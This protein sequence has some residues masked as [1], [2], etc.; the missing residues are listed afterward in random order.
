MTYADLQ[1]Q[2]R[3][4]A[5]LALTAVQY[6]EMSS[7]ERGDIKKAQAYFITSP[8]RTRSNKA[9]KAAGLSAIV[10]DLDNTTADVEGISH[11]LADANV[12]RF[13]L[14]TSLSHTNMQ[15]RYRV[16]IPLAEHAKSARW[17]V[18]ARYLNDVLFVDSDDCSKTMAQAWLL[19]VVTANGEYDFSIVDNGEP[20]DINDDNHPIVSEALKLDE[21]VNMSLEAKPVA[22][23][24]FKQEDDQLSPINV[25]NE[26]MS[27]REVMLQYGYIFK[28]KNRAVHPKSE[29]GS[30]GIYMF[31][32]GDRA[33]SHHGCDPYCGK[34]FDAFD[35]YV[36]FEHQ[37]NVR[38]A[39][40]T[41]GSELKTA[42]GLSVNEHNQKLFQMKKAYSALPAFDL[43]TFLGKA[44][45][46]QSES[47]EPPKYDVA[48]PPE[49]CFVF[50]GIGKDIYENIM[51]TAIYPQPTFALAATLM[52]MSML[53][54]GRLTG[55]QTHVRSN[56]MFICVGESGSG[57]QHN[58]NK[59]ESITRIVS[60]ELN[61]KVQNKFASGPAFWN[62]L[63]HKSQEVLLL[64]D[65]CGFLFSAIKNNKGE[66][67]AQLY[68]CFLQGYSASSTVMKPTVYAD[69]ERNSDVDIEHPHIC[70]MGFTT[71]STLSDAL[72][73][74]DSSTGLLPRLLFF[75]AVYDVPD[76][77][78]FNPAGLGS[79]ALEGLKWAYNFTNWKGD[80]AYKRKY[81]L[82]VPAT[83]EAE[84]LLD[85]FGQKNR[86]AMRSAQSMERNL[87]NRAEENARRLALVYWMDTVQP[88]DGKGNFSEEG[89]IQVGHV[90][91]AIDLVKWS[92]AYTL[93]FMTD[94]AGSTSTS[95]EIDRLISIISQAKTYSKTRKGELFDRHRGSLSKGLMPRAILVK[96]S[97]KSAKYLDELLATAGA[98]EAIGIVT[99]QVTGSTCYFAIKD[100]MQMMGEQ[101]EQKGTEGEQ[102]NPVTPTPVAG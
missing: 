97:K 25:Y 57:K 47:V 59:V 3:E 42:E 77:Q 31:P 5:K 30:A 71:E 102:A 46:T 4:P 48:P 6:Q 17:L 76:K 26:A 20:L 65:E 1:S 96:Q 79:H 28:S 29:S 12:K 70:L 62:F 92:M 99:D 55:T 16:V 83:T 73:H 89:M 88:T 23:R 33:Y 54:G 51:N 74:E 11:L 41:L 37:G 14:Y 45:T 63:G 32:E 9:V 35:V 95:K 27:I 53:G 86:I 10:L 69:K 60:P 87:L 49:R 61:K 84:A 8:A 15:P 40:K 90:E 39:I 68:D 50:S 94:K 101:K 85:D 91:Q 58:I 100:Q 78:Q 64:A 38:T 24:N 93:E 36:Q 44:Q 67:L 7:A 81:P 56:L 98:M 13:C 2:V 82:H 66:Y 43:D 52:I 18:V 34:S 22:P 21:L 19:P 72:T 80:L 75:P